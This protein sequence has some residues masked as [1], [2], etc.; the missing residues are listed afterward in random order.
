VNNSGSGTIT[1]LQRIIANTI[2]VSNDNLIEAT[3]RTAPPS[4]APPFLRLI[5]SRVGDRREMLFAATPSFR[6]R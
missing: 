5:S 4:M 6:R 1:A 3:R 2:N